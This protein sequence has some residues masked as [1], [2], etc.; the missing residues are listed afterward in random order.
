VTPAGPPAPAP[1]GAALVEWSA[2]LVRLWTELTGDL[3][4][5]DLTDA[6]RAALLEGLGAELCTALAR[7][8]EGI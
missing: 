6:D 7:W 8:T 3:R 2:S 5:G 4:A 1:S